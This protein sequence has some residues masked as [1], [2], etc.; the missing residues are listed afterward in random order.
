SATSVQMTASSAIHSGIDDRL[1]RR[2][3]LVLAAAQAIGG[4]AAPIIIAIGG[5]AGHYLLGDDKSLATLPV[6]T[7]VLGVACGTVPAALLMRRVGRRLGFQFGALFTIL[8]GALAAAAIL[9]ESFWF[10]CLGTAVSGGGNA[11]V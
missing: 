4:A 11:F 10:L 6:T 5:L 7:F 8:G 9:N 2:N 3:A 1:A